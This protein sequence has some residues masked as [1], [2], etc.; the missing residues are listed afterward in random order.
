MND[1]PFYTHTHTHMHTC[2]R[3]YAGGA[4]MEKKTFSGNV[5][6]NHSGLVFVS[7]LW[8]WLQYKM[9]MKVVLFLWFWLNGNC[10][11]LFLS[12]NACLHAACLVSDPEFKRSMSASHCQGFRLVPGT[13]LIRSL[14]KLIHDNVIYLSLETL[15]FVVTIYLLYST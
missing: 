2:T 5:D 1:L 10:I 7:G 6:M 4:C 3:A 13:Q 11:C 15:P 12:W 14:F 8:L 9:D